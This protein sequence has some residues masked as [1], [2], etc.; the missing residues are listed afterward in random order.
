M[1]KK[2]ALSWF[3]FSGPSYFP[4]QEKAREV[5]GTASRNKG[6]LSP[7]VFTLWLGQAKGKHFHFSPMDRVKKALYAAKKGAHSVWTDTS[8]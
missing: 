5:Y 2:T 4:V 7:L 1:K 3:L 8:R 6:F